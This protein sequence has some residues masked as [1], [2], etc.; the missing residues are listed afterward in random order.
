M[1]RTKRAYEPPH[2]TDGERYLV[3]RLWPRGVKKDAARLSG[4]LQEVAPSDRLRRWFGHDPAR[5]NEFCQRYFAEL[6][7]RAEAWEP[8]L[9]RAREGN[10]TLVYGAKDEQHNNARALKSY[11]E[12]KLA[13][14][15]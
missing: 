11:L 3:D 14:E 5:W 9:E 8:I 2:P 12:A 6:D 4:W 1:I 15:R 13:E 7:D 10:L